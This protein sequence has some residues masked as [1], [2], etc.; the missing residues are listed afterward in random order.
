MTLM[1]CN[2]AADGKCFQNERCKRWHPHELTSG[3][4]GL[5]FCLLVDR[6]ITCRAVPGKLRCDICRDRDA[7]Q[8]VN[9]W[10][11]C[12]DLC[13]AGAARIIKH[14]SLMVAK[15]DAR[16]VAVVDP[17]EPADEDTPPDAPIADDED[18][19]D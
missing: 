3:C 17:M 14:K 5:D 19:A 6:A 1:R 10:D 8:V 4:D 11:C 7:V 13:C 15:R 2:R 9:G 18:N 12:A 16:I